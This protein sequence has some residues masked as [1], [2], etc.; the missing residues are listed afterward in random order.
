VVGYEYQFKE[1]V[2]STLEWGPVQSKG[3]TKNIYPASKSIDEHTHIVKF[4]LTQ[5]FD[6]WRVEDNARVE[7]YD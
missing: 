6:G 7:L 3:D 2:E 1:G 4:D 5:E